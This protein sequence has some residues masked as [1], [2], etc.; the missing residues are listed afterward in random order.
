MRPFARAAAGEAGAGAAGAAEALAKA[1]AEAALAEVIAL[2]EACGLKQ[3][4]KRRADEARQWL[5]DNAS[6][7]DMDELTRLSVQ[8]HAAGFYLQSMPRFSGRVP[9][10]IEQWARDMRWPYEQHDWDAATHGIHGLR[11]MVPFRV[12]KETGAGVCD[13]VATG[14]YIAL[15]HLVE[16]LAKHVTRGLPAGD[17]LPRQPPTGDSLPRQPP[18]SSAPVPAARGADHGAWLPCLTPIVVDYVVGPLYA[19]AMRD[20][21]EAPD[22]VMWWCDFS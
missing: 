21:P 19:V 9:S 8:H 5:R 16:C 12:S 7:W 17:D 10:V 15:R 13:K 6:R 20:R 4:L 3:A 1:A 2:G 11:I 18:S 14:W 22:D